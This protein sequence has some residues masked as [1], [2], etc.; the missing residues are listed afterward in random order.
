MSSAKWPE[1]LLESECV[2]ILQTAVDM[3]LTGMHR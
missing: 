1:R 2:N 3:Q